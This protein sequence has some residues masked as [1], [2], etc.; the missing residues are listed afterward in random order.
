MPHR[1]GRTIHLRRRHLPHWMVADRPYFVTFRLKGSLP[2]E[3]ARRLRQERERFL[4]DRPSDQ[5]LQR[6]DRRQFLQLDQRLDGANTGP[7]YLEQAEVAEVVWEGFEW[8]NI[9]KGWR[10]YAATILSNHV[11]LLLQHPDGENDQLNRDLGLLKGY[12]A[13]EANRRLG[14]VGQPFWLDENFDHW[15]R[16]DR[17]VE[18]AVRYIALNPVKAGLV[19]DW[20]RWRFTRAA[21]EFAWLLEGAS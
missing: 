6:M 21:E 9:R 10:V 5:D 1:T 14:R 20:R 19:R 17:S 2:A 8:L 18:R 13:H 3:L 11:H 12:T 4:E 15:C 16:D 7:R